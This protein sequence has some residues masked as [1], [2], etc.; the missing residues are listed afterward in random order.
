VVE[1][2]ASFPRLARQ[3][4]SQL[5]FLNNQDTPLDGIA[6]LVI[7]EPIGATLRAVL[8]RI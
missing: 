2:A 6:D 8:A 1:P 3:S 5:L 4:G 7:R